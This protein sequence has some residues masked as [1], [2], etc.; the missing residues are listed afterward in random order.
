MPYINQQNII[1]HVLEN[2]PKL[3][4]ALKQFLAKNID[5]SLDEKEVKRRIE[6]K[7]LKHYKK[8]LELYADTMYEFYIVYNE[9]IW[10]DIFKRVTSR[11]MREKNQNYE[12]FDFAYKYSEEFRTMFD[13]Y[14]NIYNFEKSHVIA[15]LT[16]EM[17]CDIDII[18]NLH[19][20]FCIEDQKK[21]FLNCEVCMT[22]VKQR[23]ENQIARVIHIQKYVHE[24]N[25]Y[26]KS[27][28]S[29]KCINNEKEQLRNDY[30]K[31]CKNIRKYKDIKK[32]M[33]KM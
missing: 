15:N 11:I 7:F 21:D 24:F 19:N 33:K 32:Y 25:H 30:M 6:S 4:E 8:S 5:Y 16:R 28:V 26:D 27:C 10:L 17:K 31:R 1:N 2:I 3:A 14:I 9:H 23:W 13:K 20:K 18:K 12:T 22:D 29:F